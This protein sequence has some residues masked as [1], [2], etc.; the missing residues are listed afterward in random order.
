[1]KIPLWAALAIIVMVGA[2]AL[3]L[4][5]GP[6]EN[7]IARNQQMTAM[8]YERAA[9]TDE[10]NSLLASQG[11]LIKFRLE[12]G[13]MSMVFPGNKKLIRKDREH[14]VKMN[15]VYGGQ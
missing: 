11:Y 15:K 10:I 14:D 5:N 13:K 7:P 8:E 4:A 9:T 1:M 3:E 2:F 12:D 6:D